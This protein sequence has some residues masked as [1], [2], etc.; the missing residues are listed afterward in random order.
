M[1]GVTIRP[2]NAA[3]G[4]LGRVVLLGLAEHEDHECV[5]DERMKTRHAVAEKD[6]RR[7]FCTEWE[8]QERQLSGNEKYELERL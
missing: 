5:C 7:K 4:H 3:H 6:D 2:A 8:Q 1:C